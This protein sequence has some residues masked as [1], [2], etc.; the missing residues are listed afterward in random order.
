VQDLYG[1]QMRV[2]GFKC[3]RNAGIL[4]NDEEEKSIRAL[5]LLAVFEGSVE[6][7][8]P[9]KN[10]DKQMTFIVRVGGSF[11]K[12]SNYQKGCLSFYP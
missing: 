8:F 11:F 10:C 12:E 9:R 1:E 2:S 7:T 4:I 6:E 5:K 3:C